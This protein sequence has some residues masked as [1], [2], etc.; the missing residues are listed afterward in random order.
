M[1]R[2]FL[3]VIVLLAAIT[4]AGYRAHERVLPH[5]EAASSPHFVGTYHVHTSASHDSDTNLEDLAEIAREL[6]IDFLVVT[7]HNNQLAGPVEVNGVLVLSHAE[8][9]T[10]FGHVVQLGATELLE[11]SKRKGLGILR[12]IRKLGGIPIAAHPADPKRPWTGPVDGLGGFEIASS[13]ASARRRGGPI[14]AGLLPTAAAYWLNRDLAVAQILDRDDTALRRWDAESDPGM[15][16][17]CGVDAHGKFLGSALELRGWHTVIDAPLPV[18]RTLLPAAIIDA[19]SRGRFHC[20][21]GLVARDP[22]FEFIGAWGGEPA[23]APGDTVAATAVDALV[24]RNPRSAVDTTTMVLLRN[25]E[26]VARS[27]GGRLEYA[28]PIPGTYRV[29]VRLPIPGILWGYRMVPVIYSNRIRVVSDMDNLP[30]GPPARVGNPYPK[31]PTAAPL[32][33]KPPRRAQTQSQPPP[34]A[35]TRAK[36]NGPAG[37]AP[38]PL[39]PNPPAAP[40]PAATPPAAPPKKPPATPPAPSKKPPAA[41]PTAPAAPSPAKTAESTPS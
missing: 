41:A 36:A 12:E 25:G 26:V 13:S 34:A 17:M 19:L 3:I 6:G 33:K 18:D 15:V 5:L 1:R 10:P 4:V 20:V 23:A 14:F 32:P 37:E 27:Q 16:G 11:H 2:R 30:P 9:S 40:A 28:N 8:L 39:P 31:L 38:A 29:E 7:D 21:A 35:K 24:A 22:E